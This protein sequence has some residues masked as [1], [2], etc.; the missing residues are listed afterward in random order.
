MWSGGA[1]AVDIERPPA[2]SL[3]LRLISS[4]QRLIN[5]TDI[6]SAQQITPEPVKR[7]VLI[8]SLALVVA[9]S[10]VDRAR[11]DRE[12]ERSPAG[13]LDL[14]GGALALEGGVLV[15][16]FS[17]ARDGEFDRRA[18]GWIRHAAAAVTTYYGRFPVARARLSCTV[19]E[20]RGIGGGR[21]IVAD[22]P[23][24]HIA[25]GR[26]SGTDDFDRDWRLTHEMVHLAFP[27]VDERHHWIEEG[28]ATY[29]EP[30]ARAQ[31]G[32][33]AEEEVYAE[34]LDRM[35]LGQPGPGDL[36]LDRTDTWARTYW[37]GALFALAADVEIRAR[38]GNR[39]GL[40]DALRGIV[41]GGGSVARVWPLSRALALGDRATGVDVLTG[42]YARMATHPVPVDLDRLWARLGLRRDGG[43]VMRDPAPAPT[44]LRRAILRRP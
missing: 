37:G 25:V 18:S 29:V 44:A 16:E 23:T 8:V 41:A 14:A 39:R 19:F 17:G 2:G 22:L 20:G 40:Q 35:H 11:P 6:C 36:G 9:C 26:Y 38:T 3:D 33:L 32:W 7:R 27:R 15:L 13:A 12:R 10:G 31:S 5:E 34:W 4:V 28:L 1:H 42:A 30:V 24:I 21:L 43:G